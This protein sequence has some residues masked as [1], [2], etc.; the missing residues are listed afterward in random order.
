MHAACVSPR[1]LGTTVQPGMT[2]VSV[3]SGGVV[4]VALT[5]PEAYASSMHGPPPKAFPWLRAG[6]SNSRGLE[7]AA[8]CRRPLVMTSLPER[9]YPFRALHPGR[10]VLT[11][12]LNPAYHVPRMRPRLAPL[13]PLRVTVVVGAAAQ[14]VYSV[15]APLL[16]TRPTGPTLACSVELT[17]L[18]PAGCSGVPVTGVDISRLPGAHRLRGVWE[19]GPLRLI[20]TW[21]GRALQ[22]TQPAVVSHT[23]PPARPPLS[24]RVPST[25]LAS[26]LANRIAA[27]HRGLD[28]LATSP[29]GSVA[30]VL[31]A[32]RDARTVAAIHAR[33]GRRIVVSGLLR[34]VAPAA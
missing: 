3:A 24:C 5:E 18:P 13:H 27:H 17:S 9:L 22:V 20:G 2:E 25:S 6:S 23:Q 32:V 31:V 14:P 19:T 4:T 11:S 8:V 30:W 29:C 16:R 7:P 26:M 10:Y 28:V 12:P 34:P 1:A 33:Y 21:N 15:L